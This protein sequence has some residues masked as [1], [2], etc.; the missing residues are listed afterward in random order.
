MT[1]ARVA[2]TPE[3]CTANHSAIPATTYGASCHTFSH[4]SSRIPTTIA[5]RERE[6]GHVDLVRVEDRHHRDRAD[7]VDDR[8]REQEEP[9]AVRAL[10]PEQGEDADEER[11]VGRHHDAPAVGGVGAA[12]ERQEDQHGDQQPAERAQRGDRDGPPVPQVPGGRLAADLQADHREEDRHRRVVDPVVQVEVDA[13]GPQ[14]E[15]RGGAPEGVVG[16]G[17]RGVDPD[18]RDDRGGQQ[19]DGAAGLVGEEV[20][21]GGLQPGQRDPQVGPRGGGGRRHVA[22]G[23]R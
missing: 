7:V 22:Q 4:R 19:V 13:P 12:V 15:A 8:E 2:C 16:V 20:L 1:P 11:G 23:R 14:V 6:G 17:E 3:A 9:Q 5:R 18:Q 21:D 10:R